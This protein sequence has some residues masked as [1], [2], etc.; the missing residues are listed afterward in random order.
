MDELQK[1]LYSEG[2]YKEVVGDIQKWTMS[3][4]INGHLWNVEWS[5]GSISAEC[6]DC[7]TAISL[8]DKV[9]TVDELKEFLNSLK[10]PIVDFKSGFY[11]K[12]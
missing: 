9:E 11:T 3:Q 12:H 1:Y 4:T 2:W 5:Y 10:D 6:K 7:H 8:L